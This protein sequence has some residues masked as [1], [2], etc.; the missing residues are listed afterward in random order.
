MPGWK[1]S[2]VLQ[3]DLNVST[4]DSLSKTLEVVDNDH[5]KALFQQ[6]VL[7]TGGKG[8]DSNLGNDQPWLQR[9]LLEIGVSDMVT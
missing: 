3:V 6:S 8:R 9:R 5:V 7:A 1:I 2:A 4:K